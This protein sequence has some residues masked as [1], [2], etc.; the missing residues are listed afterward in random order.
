[1]TNDATQII[2]LRAVKRA[3]RQAREEALLAYQFAPNSYTYG[4][5]AQI[6][7]LLVR[8]AELDEP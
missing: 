7:L 2:L 1:M 8:L 6:D 3:A 4:A 5:L